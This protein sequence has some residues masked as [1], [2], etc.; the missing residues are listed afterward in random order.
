MGKGFDLWVVWRLYWTALPGLSTMDLPQ[1][2]G[3]GSAPVKIRRRNNIQHQNPNQ[4][5]DEDGGRYEALVI[6]FK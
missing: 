3:F 1:L 4:S 5:D 6:F 2:E